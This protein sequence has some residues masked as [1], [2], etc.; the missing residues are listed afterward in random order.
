MAE[1]YLSFK[2][3]NVPSASGELKMNNMLSIY[4]LYRRSR[5]SVIKT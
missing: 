5:Y 3:T 1:A 2:L 4:W